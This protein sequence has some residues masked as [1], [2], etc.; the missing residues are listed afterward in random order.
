METFLIVAI[1]GIGAAMFLGAVASLVDAWL[2]Q[3][4]GDGEPPTR[5]AKEDPDGA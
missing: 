4:K 3:R 1:G 2:A 5:V